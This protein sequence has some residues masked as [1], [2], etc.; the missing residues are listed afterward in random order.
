MWRVA[1]GSNTAWWGSTRIISTELAPFGGI[2]ESGLGR[3]GAAEGLEEYLET[4][5]LCFG[6][7]R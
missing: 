7:I 6:G 3:E 5:Y 4:K 2:K 1:E